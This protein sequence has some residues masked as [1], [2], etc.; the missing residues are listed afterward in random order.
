MNPHEHEGTPDHQ[1]R[2]RRVTAHLLHTTPQGTVTAAHSVRVNFADDPQALLRAHA[3]LPP[4]T[5]ITPLDT[6]TELATTTDPAT[7][8]RLAMHIDRLCYTTPTPAGP[9]I[10]L[11]QALT[12]LHHDLPARA[13][14]DHEPPRPT[15][16]LRRFCAYGLVTDPAGRIL[17]SRIAPGFPGAGTWHL[18]GGGTD[19]GEDTHTALTR[20]IT[21]ETGQDATPGRLITITHHHRTNQTGPDGTTGEIY[22]VWVFLSAYV[23]RPCTPRVTETAGST[24]DASWFTPQ[25]LAGLTLSTTARQAITQQHRS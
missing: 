6:R 11:D 21:E 25:E 23:A 8:A 15:L 2:P 18:P 9:A 17:L 14:T 22:A 24:V 7:G 20:E 10:P 19:H 4:T 1:R 3:D 16:A 13:L 12:R 5:A